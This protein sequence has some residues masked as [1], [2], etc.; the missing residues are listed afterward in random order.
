[1]P[2]PVIVK[3]HNNKG[4]DQEV[5][6]AL[7]L[8]ANAGKALPAGIRLV[9]SYSEK[10]PPEVGDETTTGLRPDGFDYG[11]WTKIPLR[12]KV[13]VA[14]TAAHGP[15]LAAGGELTVCKSTCTITS[16]SIVPALMIWSPHTPHQVK[17]PPYRRTS[18]STC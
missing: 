3:L 9:L 8:P 2:L 4:L 6:A 14:T 16:K 12:K 7:T 10:L 18:C 13:T 1:M 15:V 11:K 17:Q 5:P